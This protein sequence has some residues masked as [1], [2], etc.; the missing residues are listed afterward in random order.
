[1]ELCRDVVTQMFENYVGVDWAQDNM[2]IAVL[3]TLDGKY[4]F[5]EGKPNIVK[6]KRFLKNIPG[7]KRLIIEE[8]TSTHWLFLELLGSVDEIA[9]CDPYE[10]KLMTHGPKTD[11]ID[12]RK[13]AEYGRDREMNLV[14][15]STDGIVKL[16]RLVSGYED[17]I[18]AIVRAKNQNSAV[19]RYECKNYK[20]R[21]ELHWVESKFVIGLKEKEIEFLEQQ[22]SEYEKAFRKYLRRP[23]IRNLTSVPGIGLIGA[24]KAA[25]IIVNPHRFKDKSKYFGYCGLAKHILMSGGRCYG[26]RRT[27]YNRVLKCVF[28]TAAMAV[29][30]SGN[31]ENKLRKY[32]DMLLSKGFEEHA[33]RNAVA[34]KIAVILLSVMKSRKKYDPD[35]IKI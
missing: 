25:A 6:A 23:E 30:N 29:L 19:Y 13:L 9:V 34:R 17:L 7:T 31:E 28:K 33:A 2:A 10:N 5:L 22:K 35:L 11:R 26:K 1:M 24:I 4:R 3:N 18:K 16:R 32:Y 14:F 12:A 20:K 27:R 8:T 15:H 21:E